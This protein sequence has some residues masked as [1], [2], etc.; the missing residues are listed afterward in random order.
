MFNTFAHLIGIPKE[1]G[2]RDC[3]GL[4]DDCLSFIPPPHHGVVFLAPHSKM[5]PVKEEQERLLLE[6]LAGQD[7]S[8]VGEGKVWY[9]K[10]LVGNAC[11]T[12]AVLH[13]LANAVFSG[14]LS[15]AADSFLG[16]FM[17]R[18]QDVSPLMR[19]QVFETSEGIEEVHMQCAR[20]GQTATPEADAP[21]DSHFVAFTFADGRLYELDG[22][23]IGP[24]DHGP[25]T[26]ET[27][28]KDTMKIIQKEFIDRLDSTELFFSLITFGPAE[29]Q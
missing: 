25:T 4:D 11:G 12:I 27:F 19:G 22:G 28:L 16:K 20:T 26:A 7:P 1:F 8:R 29:E 10:Q 9:M 23:K 15:V 21:V 18:C 24:V 17:A 5:K 3:F 6:K 14:R 13:V 2:F